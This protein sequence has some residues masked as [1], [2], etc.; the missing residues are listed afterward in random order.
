MISCTP[1]LLHRVSCCLTVFPIRHLYYPHIRNGFSYL[2]SL[3]PRMSALR[4]LY[5]GKNLVLFMVSK[6]S[7]RVVPCGQVSGFADAFVTV[8]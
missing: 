8:D 7:A 1:F 6:F 2:S 3:L 5:T 4:L